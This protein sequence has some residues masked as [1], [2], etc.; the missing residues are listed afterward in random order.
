MTFNL[1][2]HTKH[3][4]SKWC[5][6]SHPVK[7]HIYSKSFQH[8]VR[9]SKGHKSHDESYCLTS[10]NMSYDQKRPRNLVGNVSLE[11]LFLI[12]N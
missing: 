10:V 4:L 6:L 12:D 11:D 8:T 5:I 3:I 9:Y 2:F 1:G 7:V